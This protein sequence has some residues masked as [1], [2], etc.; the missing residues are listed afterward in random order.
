MKKTRRLISFILVIA[1]LLSVLPAGVFGAASGISSERATSR[2]EVN[3]LSEKG[4]TPLDADGLETSKKVTDNKDGSYTITLENYTTGTITSEEVSAPVDIVLVLDQSGSMSESFTG[5]ASRQAALKTA[6]NN[7]ITAVNGNYSNQADNRIAIITFG[8][9]PSTKAGWTF[10]DATGKTTLQGAVNSLPATISNEATETDEGM[11]AA[12][13]LMGSGYSYSGSNKTRQKVVVLFTDG[14]PTSHEWVDSFFS[15]KTANQAIASANRMKNNGILVYTVGIQDGADSSVYDL[16]NSG[17]YADGDDVIPICNRF[18]NYTSSNFTPS[19]APDMGGSSNEDARYVYFYPTANYTRTNT[20]YYLAA[21][22]ASG[23]NSVFQTISSQIATPTISLGVKTAHVDT[24][25]PYFAIVEGTPKAYT[26]D[27]DGEKFAGRTDWIPAEGDLVV[28]KANNRV[29]LK[30]FDYDANVCIPGT[31]GGKKLILEF[32]IKPKAEFLGGNGV[33]T[34]VQSESGVKTDDTLIENYVADYGEDK[35]GVDVPLAEI[36]LR[37]PEQNVY[38]NGDYDEGLIG[39]LEVFNGTEWVSFETWADG[40]EDR[41]KA[42][43]KEL[44]PTVTKG[45]GT[46]KVS[47]DLDPIYT[48]TV[49]KKTFTSDP[50]KLNIFKP[51]LTFKDETYTFTYEE[52]LADKALSDEY[53]NANNYESSKTVWKCGEALSTAVTMTGEEP[54]ITLT[55]DPAA[56]KVTDKGGDY[57][58]KVTVKTNDK[59]SGATFAWEKD[60]DCNATCTAAPEGAQ[61][62]IHKAS[63]FYVIHHAEDGSADMAETIPMSALTGGSFDI[64]EAIEDAYDGIREGYLYSGLYNKDYTEVYKEDNW[65]VDYHGSA[66][67]GKA[68]TPTAGDVY[69]LKEVPS[70]YLRPKTLSFY[71]GED[72][73]T[74]ADVKYSYMI[75]VVDSLN[76]AYA[77][78]DINGASWKTAVNNDTV[79]EELEAVTNKGTS[80]LNPK[81]FGSEET[82]YIVCN[83]VTSALKG[84]Q[85]G[86]TDLTIQPYFV[87]IDGVKVT[88]TVERTMN[89]QEVGL[90]VVQA[91]TTVDSVTSKYVE[92]PAKLMR[93]LS[94]APNL[95]LG[96]PETAEE[97]TPETYTI[98]KIVNGKT[99]EQIVEAGSCVGEIT[100]PEAAGKVFTGWFM[101][102]G[103]KTPADFTDIES[104]MTVYAKYVSDA[105]LNVFAE[106]KY[107]LLTGSKIEMCFAVPDTEFESVGFVYEAKGEENVLSVVSY[108]QRKNLK[109]A[110]VL[111]GSKVA[112]DAKLVIGSIAAA[113]MTNG[114]SITVRAYWTTLDGTTV[115]GQAETVT[116]RKGLLW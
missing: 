94:L 40:L 34:N 13:N 99:E 58:V 98:T 17:I 89:Y 110:R 68:L 24:V 102:A 36:K 77:G 70:T 35:E 87:T 82:G 6:V 54:T 108:S 76:Y 71:N 31:S 48:G 4:D 30:G 115:Y 95:M 72:D 61:F 14:Q 28:D 12:E 66:Y 42:F 65:K 25:S 114:T 46:Y 26:A 21:K 103:Y 57:V 41:Q 5:A 86:E 104:D 32:Q 59:A 64:T 106:S 10:V 2:N 91:D 67:N 63:V 96:V 9:D 8:D 56:V 53:Y 49:T 85:Q 47:V 52:L 45:D 19:N 50:S 39:G 109:T 44:V 55:Y 78:F 113:G 29:T 18:L 79:Y 92:E 33:P 74:H 75:T 60:N 38:E 97:E 7:F 3:D 88:G 90:P 51:V 1:M 43:V 84:Y 105:Y 22:D 111:F 83:D 73:K 80:K 16:G 37:V 62:R 93:M 100:Y 81:N 11:T 20:G 23:L 107:G 69:Y 27:Y 112:K 116:F 15:T 101:D